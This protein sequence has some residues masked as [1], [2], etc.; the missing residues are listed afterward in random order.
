[1]VNMEKNESII[2]IKGIGDKVYGLFNKVGVFTCDDLIHYYP[3]AY[4]KYENL[5]TFNSSLSGERIAVIGTVKNNP[6]INKFKNKVIVSF[7]ISDGDFSCEVRFFNAAYMAKAVKAGD[8]KVF[9]GILRS[10]K[11]KLLMDQPKIF[12][13]EEYKSLGEKIVPIYPLTKELTNDRIKKSIQFALDN[14][15][16][17]KDFLTLE[18]CNSLKMLPLSEAIKEIHF[19]KNNDNL[20]YS[21]RR[22]IFSEF[23]EF[24][25]LQRRDSNISKQVPNCNPMVEVSDCKRLEESLPYTLTNA[26]KKAIKEISLD[27]SGDYLMNRCV[28]GDVGSGKTII[29][30][31]ALLMCAANGYQGAMMAPTEVLARQHFETIKGLTDKYGL[32]IKPVLLNGK[33]GAKEKRE[34]LKAIS[35]NEANVIIGTHALIQEN[36]SFSNLALVITDEQHRFGVKQRENLSEKG[37]QPHLLVMSATPIPRTLAMVVFAGLSVSIIDEL[38]KN[39]IPIQ[40]C[41]VNSSFRIKAYEKIRSEIDKGHQ[42]YVICPMVYENEEDA[43]SLK[44]VEEHSKEIAEYFGDK[45]RIGTLSGK[46]KPDEKTRIM[47]NFK[48]KNI[49]ILVSTTVIEVGIDVPN[50]TVIMIEN[51]E[52]FGLSQLHQLRGRVGRGNFE[53]FC[54]LMSDSKKEETIKRLEIL[55]K[56]NDGFKIASE[57]MKLRGPGELNGVRQSGELSFGLGDIVEDGDLMLLASEYYEKVKDR[58]PN[59]NRKLIDFRSI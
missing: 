45:Y 49:D 20:Y 37:K 26:Q 3:R 58:M 11:D 38:P 29:A 48:D 55:N 13:V 18:E 44:S 43:L 16:I 24:I 22:I 39:R 31:M 10:F 15:E 47:E 12:S 53:S 32:S 35:N 1:M 34:A 40:N 46:M 33:M 27:M 6:K 51:A 2:K 4:D 30:V 36:V 52:R 42:A 28:Q 21:R 19:P 59:L 9:R 23:L 57:D 50:A 8:K 14:V 7:F 41:V 17:D 54:I 25:A 5:S 56:T